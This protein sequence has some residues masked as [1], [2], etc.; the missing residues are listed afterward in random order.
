[1]A[2]SR[3]IIGAAPVI[4]LVI[5]AFLA[6]SGEASRR[7]AGDDVWTPA[8]ESAAVSGNNGVVV[9]FL[10]QIYLQRLG[11]GPSCGTNSSNGGCPRHP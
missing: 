8:G 9:Q 1:M 3:K 4:I 10:R 7:L 5:M 6:V 11:A 2:I